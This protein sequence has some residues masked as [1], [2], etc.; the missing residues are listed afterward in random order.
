VQNTE[1]LA[2]LFREFVQG[3][4]DYVKALLGELAK[5]TG[6]K[7][8]LFAAASACLVL[9][10]IYLSMALIN[11]L[12]VLLLSPIWPYVIVGGALLAAAALLFM[13][14]LGKKP[15]EADDGDHE[16]DQ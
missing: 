10:L 16:A 12:T 6:K 9:A 14:A 5:T 13:V 4:A 15:K 3:L 1:S 11:W 7:M 8:A 2:D